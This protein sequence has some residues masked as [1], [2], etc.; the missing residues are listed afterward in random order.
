VDSF[1]IDA[2][3]N[4]YIIDDT[5]ACV[6]KWSP[7]YSTGILVAGG[8]G[9][10]ATLT[11]LN[12]PQALFVEPNTSIIWIADTY[13]CRIVKWTSPSTAIL[14]AGGACGSKP[15]QFNYPAGLYVDT[16]ASNT[17]YVVDTDNHR[18]QMWISGSNNG[19]TVAGQ[20]G[21][22]GSALNQLSSPVSLIMDK[23]GSMYI[24]DTGN[25]RIILWTLGF[26]SG[27][28]IAGVDTFGTLPNQIY[29]PLSIRFDSSGALIVADSGNN[30]I[31]RFSVV[32]CKYMNM[33]E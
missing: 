24:V 8:N 1:S 9:Q 13:N 28:V 14:V 3:G 7:G 27:V 33:C 19:T 11:K 12:G 22:A 5:N 10:G 25:Y 6:T 30:R 31:Q 17:L 4:I 29:Y 20:T 26:T 15:S 21:V 2:S 23:N 18:I 32:C 16:S